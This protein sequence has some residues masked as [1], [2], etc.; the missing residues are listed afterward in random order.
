MNAAMVGMACPP[1]SGLMNSIFQPWHASGAWS[2]AILMRASRGRLVRV[3]EDRRGLPEGRGA[4]SG[5]RPC[6]KRA[7]DEL[8][9][10]ETGRT[11]SRNLGELR[12]EGLHDADVEVPSI[13]TRA[14]GSLPG[15][16]WSCQAQDGVMMKSPGRIVVRS[17]STAV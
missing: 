10:R 17:P 9:L 14:T 2:R 4:P 15:L 7:A 13:Q 1:V 6:P 12:G 8:S 5:T 3:V 16:P 11:S